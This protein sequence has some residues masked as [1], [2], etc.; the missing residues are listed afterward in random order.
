MPVIVDCR[1]CG[2]KLRITDDLLGRKVKCPACGEIFDAED[3][4][5]EPPDNGS[6]P[7]WES[8]P[9]SPEE[10]PTDASAKGEDHRPWELPPPFVGRRDCEPERGAIVLTMGIASLLLPLLGFPLGLAAWIMGAKDLRKMREGQMDPRGQGTTQA[11]Q[12][13]GIVG[14]V[15]QALGILTCMVPMLMGLIAATTAIRSVPPPRPPATM[16][17]VPTKKE[18]NPNEGEIENDPELVPA[19]PPR[20]V[21]PVK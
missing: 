4:P 16:F 21:T 19:Q 9:T 11:G 3:A 15:F 8:G 17:M 13:C 20:R 10:K 2:H 5:P 1:S 7:K 18:F 14:L 6:R 12:I